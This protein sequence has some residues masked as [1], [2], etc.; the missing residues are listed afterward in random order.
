[1]YDLDFLV[2]PFKIESSESVS[3]ETKHETV[4]LS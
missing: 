4:S 1:M 3:F 2:P